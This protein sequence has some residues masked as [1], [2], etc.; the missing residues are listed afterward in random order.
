TGHAAQAE[1][2]CL[3]GLSVE[4]DPAFVPIHL[5]LSTELIGLRHKDLVPQQA[6]GSLPGAHILTNRRLRYFGFRFLAAQ[7]HPDPVRRVPLLSWC[8]AIAFQNRVNEWDRRPK[9]R[10]LTLRNFAF[11]R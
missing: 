11:S 6:H 4:L 1:H 8:L 9:F 2:V 3:A 5:R 10:S 7:S